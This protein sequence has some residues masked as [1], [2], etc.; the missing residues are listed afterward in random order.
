MVNNVPFYRK[1][2]IYMHS[3]SVTENENAFADWFKTKFFFVNWLEKMVSTHVKIRYFMFV[4]TVFLYRWSNM[5]F[6]SS[7]KLAYKRMFIKYCS[8]YLHPWTLFWKSWYIEFLPYHETLQVWLRQ[9]SRIWWCRYGRRC[10]WFC[11][12][13]KGTY[14]LLKKQ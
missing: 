4:S 7:E 10:H 5:I 8:P 1:W 3:D 13:Y 6:L 2:G 12:R 9:S 14:E 11:W